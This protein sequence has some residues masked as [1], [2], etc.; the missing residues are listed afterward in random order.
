[1]SISLKQL[2]EELKILAN[3][4]HEERITHYRNHPA[5]YDTIWDDIYEMGEALASA[6]T[7]ENESQQ[8]SM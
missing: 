1:M 3:M 2:E 8:S 5:Q 7:S 6:D 4:S